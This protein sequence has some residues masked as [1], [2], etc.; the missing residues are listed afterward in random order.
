[1]RLDARG[2][3]STQRLTPLQ[4][5]QHM[6]ALQ[7]Q[8]S[9]WLQKAAV[10]VCSVQ[11]CMCQCLQVDGCSVQVV[12]CIPYADGMHPRYP[13]P[14]MSLRGKRTRACQHTPYAVCRCWSMS[15]S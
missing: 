3:V 9:A 2:G 11:V 10:D 15:R 14:R 12:E 4:S 1:M 5:K 13:R 7:S 8:H 6:E